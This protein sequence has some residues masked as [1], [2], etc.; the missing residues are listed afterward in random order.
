MNSMNLIPL[1]GIPKVKPGDEISTFIIKSI[2]RKKIKISKNDLIVIAHKIVSISENRFV[3]LNKVKVGKRAISLSKKIDKSKEFCQLILDNSKKIIKIKKG[4]IITENR[5]GII[6]ANAGIDQS[7]I[8]KK[9]FC[10]L[11][12]LNPNATARKISQAIYQE[13][14]K[15]LGSIISYS[16]GRP[17]SYG[18]TQIS[19][20]SFGI[21][22]IKKYK[23]DLFK[24]NLYDTEV[25]IV[26]EI[27][28]AAGILME[29]DIGIPVV[30]IK[31]Y[32]YMK[33]NKDSNI[34]LRSGEN[35]IFK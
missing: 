35:D 11:L 23:K 28:S 22:P 27:A 31:G 8:N 26:D 2:K 20:G 7:N 4:V 14:G 18:L 16:V 6:T 17:W 33:S 24:N 30:L 13:T 10:L 32:N 9:D 12:P 3:E 19:I 25:P 5:L 1:T 34:L 29:K 15:K 21:S